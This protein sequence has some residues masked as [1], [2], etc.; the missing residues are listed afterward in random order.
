MRLVTTT[1]VAR[2]SGNPTTNTVE[3]DLADLRKALEKAHKPAT[4]IESCIAR[5]RI[6]RSKLQD[7]AETT[8]DNDTN[9][10]PST[11]PLVRVDSALPAEFADYFRGAIAWH[12]TNVT[13]ARA[14]WTALLKRPPAERPYKS[15]W[16]AFM[17]GKSWEDENQ[18]QRP[19]QLEVG[20]VR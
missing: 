20:L 14:E 8:A 3:M 10:P 15:T 5:F 1:N 4:E 19:R 17:L 16:A 9:A 11:F 2:L 12:Q 6:E 18:R 7:F 13:T